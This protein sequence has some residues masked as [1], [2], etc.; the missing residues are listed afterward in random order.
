MAQP[1]PNPHHDFWRGHGFIEQRLLHQTNCF[2]Q[3]VYGVSVGHGHG[4]LNLS[5]KDLANHELRFGQADGIGRGV[6]PFD[7]DLRQSMDGFAAATTL[8]LNVRAALFLFEFSVGDGWVCGW[9]LSLVFAWGLVL[10]LGVAH[11]YLLHE[12]VLVLKRL[13]FRTGGK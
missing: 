11:G 12:W 7:F 6:Y 5:L 9:T 10:I 4:L 3:H 2:A 8:A 1:L 13:L